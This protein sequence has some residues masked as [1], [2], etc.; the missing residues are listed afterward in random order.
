MLYPHSKLLTVPRNCMPEVMKKKIYWNNLLFNLVR[1]FSISISMYMLILAG[2][3]FLVDQLEIDKIISYIIISSFS[4]IFEYM[5]T[6]L[7]V[8]PGHHQWLKVL[9]FLIHTSFFIAIGTLIYEAL[10]VMQVQYLLATFIAAL[11]L[12]PLRYISNKYFV[13]R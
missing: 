8:F 2:M 6:L 3:Y 4:Y 5:L 9:K 12:L 10:L 11:L 1:Y 7:F 13:Y